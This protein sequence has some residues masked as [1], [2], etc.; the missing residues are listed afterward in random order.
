MINDDESLI[1]MDFE[2]D[3]YLLGCTTWDIIGIICWVSENF[4]GYN[5]IY[6]QPC[7]IGLY[8]VIKL[9]WLKNPRTTRPGKR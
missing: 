6:S 7:S 3:I 8:R 1:K 4:M 2:L 9:G 5:G